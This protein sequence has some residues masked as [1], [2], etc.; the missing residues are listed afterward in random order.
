MGRGRVTKNFC[1]FLW[2]GVYEKLSDA[3]CVFFSGKFS[4]K[5]RP[6]RHLL[7]IYIRKNITFAFHGAHVWRQNQSIGAFKNPRQFNEVSLKKKTEEE[8]LDWKEKAAMLF[9]ILKMELM[10]DSPLFMIVHSPLIVHSYQLGI[11]AI[12][13]K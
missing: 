13:Q 11:Q 8:D 4:D 9:P 12:I 7:L 3:P 1:N 10:N 2:G 5:F 6:K